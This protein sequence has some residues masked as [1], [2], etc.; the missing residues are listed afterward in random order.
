M[1]KKNPVERFNSRFE[2]AEERTRK[3]KDKQWIL[4]SVRNRKKKG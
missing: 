4:L 3:L 2:T 1:K